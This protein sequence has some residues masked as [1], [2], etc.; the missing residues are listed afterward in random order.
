MKALT[1]FA[2]CYLV[3]NVRRCDFGLV[4][5][6]HIRG[7]VVGGIWLKVRKSVVCLVDPV[8]YIFPLSIVIDGR[9]VF[10]GN[11]PRQGNPPKDEEAGGIERTLVNTNL[12]NLS[13]V[14]YVT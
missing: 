10:E 14:I 11:V 1:P 3:V 5:N 12:C 2:G 6:P 13:I 9:Q 4:F 7:H 8:A